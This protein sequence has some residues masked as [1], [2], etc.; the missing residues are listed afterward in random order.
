MKYRLKLI[1][2]GLILV[3]LVFSCTKD[4]DEI[5]TDPHGFT[6]ASDGSLFNAIIES[7]VLTGNEQFYINNEILYKQTELAALTKEAWG[8]FTLGTEDMWSNYYRTLPNFRELGYRFDAMPQTGE[9]I[10]MKAMLK[11]VL[12]YKTFKLTDIFGDMPFFDAGYGFQDLEYLRPKFDKQEAIYKYLLDE[13]KWCDENINDTATV[14]EPFPT[15]SGFDRLF[16][17]DMLMWQKFGNSL[18]LRYAMRMSEKEPQLAAEIIQEIIENE[19]PL[20]LGY[21]FI[22]YVGESVCIWPSQMGFKNESLNWSFREHNNLRMGS[23]IW[24]RLSENDST[25]GS[26]IFDPRAYIF[27][28]PNNAGD[29]VAFPQIPDLNTPISGGIPYGSHRDQAGAFQIKGEGCIYSPFNYFIVRDEDFMPIPLYTGAETHFILA[30][31]YLRGIGLPQDP[32]MAE[33]EYMNGI[34]TSITWWKGVSD[35]SKL[36][37]SGLLFIDMSPIPTNLNV[38]TVL[39]HFA[40]WLVETDEEKL[41]F[42]YTQRWLDAFRQPW[43]AYALARRTGKTPREGDLIH[44]YRMPYPPSEAEYNSANWAEAVSRQGG[45]A[46][47]FKIWWIP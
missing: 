32:D 35:N 21:D 41:E 14:V 46:P 15:F 23:N 9:V 3:S 47:E 17:G 18:R 2:L 11:V 1:G 25:D 24:H 44:H 38:V 8:N 22:T 13:L 42:V 45:D 27:F 30:E 43:E 5:N 4:F 6:T 40:F 28:E 26:G 29:W 34:T 12:A 20:I 36:P 37:V 31:A 16:N 33:I 10:N 7:L 39:N 19:R